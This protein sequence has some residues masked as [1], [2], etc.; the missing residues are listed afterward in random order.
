MVRIFVRE[1]A[2]NF[3]AHMLNLRKVK[4]AIPLAG[5]AHARERNVDW[6]I[7]SLASVVA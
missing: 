1:G 7:A 4:F 3:L 6:R 5:R 2:A